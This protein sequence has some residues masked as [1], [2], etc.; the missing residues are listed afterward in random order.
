MGAFHA[1]LREEHG[2]NALVRWSSATGRDANG[3][4]GQLVTAKS[5]RAQLRVPRVAKNV[6]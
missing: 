1:R 5:G 2:V 3:A 6:K 4:C